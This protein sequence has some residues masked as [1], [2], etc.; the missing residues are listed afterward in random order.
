MS[1]R[2]GKRERQARKRPRRARTLIGS[3]ANAHWLKVGRKHSLRWM[4][5]VLDSRSALPVS[6]INDETAI[7]ETVAG[8]VQ[9]DQDAR[10]TDSVS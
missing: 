9:I 1:N 3:G 4:R 7:G 2:L 8:D 10:A 6:L 5:R